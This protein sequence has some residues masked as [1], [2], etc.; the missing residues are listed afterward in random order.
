[1]LYF[2]ALVGLIASC[3]SYFFELDKGF[4]FTDL[5]KENGYSRWAKDKEIQMAKDVVC[6]TAHGKPIK[7]KTVGQQKYV[8]SIKKNTIVF[9]I[10]PA[11]TGKT[12]LAVAMAVT[13]LKQ[14]QCKRVA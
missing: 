13:A 2:L 11:G 5:P 1:M 10:G 6:I 3:K 12:F 4:G 8:D 9:G 14:K 7:A